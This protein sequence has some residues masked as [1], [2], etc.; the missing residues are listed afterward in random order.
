MKP[1]TLAVFASVI[2]SGCGTVVPNTVDWSSDST[3]ARDTAVMVEN[4]TLSVQC[5][6]QTA[7][8]RIVAEESR[9]APG[10]ANR[11]NYVEFLEDWGAEVALTLTIV[12][13]T[14]L[15]PTVL[16]APPSAPSSIF[17]I[18]GGFSLANKATRLEKINLFYTVKELNRS[19]CAKSTGTSSPLIY[20]DLKIAGILESRLLLSVLG[21]ARDP[22]DGPKL[23]GKSQGLTHQV[24]FQVVSSGSLTPSWKLVRA[25][26]NPTGTLASTSRDRTHDLV[27]TFGPL[28][29][30][31]D[32]R[33]LIQSAQQSHFITQVSSG[34]STSISGLTA[35]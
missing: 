10:R 17:T 28:D 2:L 7:V 34:L 3:D 33:S 11:R 24:T 9:R 27:V 22:G 15:N 31:S 12:E 20:N 1:T 13:N 23:V 30:R 4:I 25:T 6:L 21:R 18:S 19:G 32:G 8:A 16:L 26:I 35:R 29:G 14:T 5:E